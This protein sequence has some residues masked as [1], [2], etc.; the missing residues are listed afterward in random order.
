MKQPRTIL[1][2][3]FKCKQASGPQKDIRNYQIKQATK[4]KA[5]KIEESGKDKRGKRK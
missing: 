2:R 1:M 4:A 5:A 3:D